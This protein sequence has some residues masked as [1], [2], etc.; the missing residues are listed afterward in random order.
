MKRSSMDFFADFSELASLASARK[1][2]MLALAAYSDPVSFPG[3]SVQ[4]LRDEKTSARAVCG[5]AATHAV[6]VFPGTESASDLMTD[7]DIGLK[8]WQEV[9]SSALTGHAPPEFHAGFLDCMTGAVC[10]WMD[11]LLPTLQSAHITR[12]DVVGHSLG[13]ALAQL[14]S[15]YLAMLGLAGVECTTFGSP[16]VGNDGAARVASE[17][18]FRLRNF[19]ARE[20]PVV[21]LPPQSFGYWRW[22]AGV[23]ADMRPGPQVNIVLPDAKYVS[24]SDTW[25]VN[26]LNIAQ[27]HMQHY[28]DLINMH[29]PSTLSEHAFLVVK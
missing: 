14:A 12:V 11:G 22:G 18:P 13:G 19:M 20:D 10:A 4:E 17:K 1:L 25:S 29:D 26:P 15:L 21:M 27:H 5:L 24:P 9:S 6:I 3:Y 7:L 8:P 28:L 23:G 16:M 2:A